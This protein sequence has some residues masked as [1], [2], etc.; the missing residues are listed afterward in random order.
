MIYKLEFESDDRTEWCQAKSL[1]H[2]QEAYAKEY[3]QED[4][5]DIKSITI[6][7]TE[8]AKIIMLKNNDYDESDPE[9]PKVFS[10]FDAV[11]GDDFCIVG[12]T[13][14]E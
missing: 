4:V 5:I 6:I 3:S 1:E 8:A 13:E 14:W 11:V 9:S 12:S 7:D 10:L 2:L